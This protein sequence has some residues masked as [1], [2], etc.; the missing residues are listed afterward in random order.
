MTRRQSLGSMGPFRV[1]RV[2]LKV[3]SWKM[4]VGRTSPEGG[5]RV[6]GGRIPPLGGR[7]PPV[8]N[9]LRLSAP[10]RGARSGC[11]SRCHGSS[12]STRSKSVYCWHTLRGAVQLLC[13]T[14]GLLPPWRDP[15]PGYPLSSLRDGNQS[16]K[17]TPPSPDLRPSTDRTSDL[18]RLQ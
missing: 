9:P 3:G 6:A 13:L 14:G 15:T 8:I 16:S 17:Q 11:R 1:L 12:F 4:N 5:Q 7:R 2:S 10:R 18:Q